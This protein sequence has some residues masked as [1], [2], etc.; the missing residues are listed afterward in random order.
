[1]PNRLSILRWTI[2]LAGRLPAK[3][4]PSQ[5]HD[6]TPAS[7]WW[8]RF[9]E[10]ERALWR[11]TR[12]YSG[13]SWCRR[14]CGCCRT[15]EGSLVISCPLLT[16]HKDTTSSLRSPLLKTKPNCFIKAS[17]SCDTLDFLYGMGC[18]TQLWSAEVKSSPIGPDHTWVWQP[19]LYR[20]SSVS[21][22]K[23][24]REW[25]PARTQQVINEFCS[26]LGQAHTTSWS[27]LLHQS[28]VFSLV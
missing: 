9:K 1:M 10:V 23:R 16:T 7:R 2:A 13:F 18:Q 26:K 22:E 12:C 24:L 14:G 27:F 11:R 25:Y 4:W 20:K 17:L 5:W 21:H 28:S 15:Q 8:R 3:G 19:M 6:S